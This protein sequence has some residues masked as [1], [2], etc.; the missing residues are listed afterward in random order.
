MKWRERHPESGPSLNVQTT[1]RAARDHVA[2]ALRQTGRTEAVCAEESCRVHRAGGR[3]AVFAT[4]GSRV[5]RRTARI[6]S[7]NCVIQRIQSDNAQLESDQRKSS[8]PGRTIGPY[9]SG[10]FPR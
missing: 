10:M 8:G 7:R 2:L 9:P 4:H 6:C 1:R 5:R 3:Y